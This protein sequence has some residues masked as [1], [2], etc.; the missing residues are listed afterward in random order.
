MSGWRAGVRRKSWWMT[1]GESLISFFRSTLSMCRSRIRP[2]A[3]YYVNSSQ[4][5]ELRLKWGA[6]IV[7]FVSE[8][9]TFSFSSCW[10]MAPWAAA[11]IPSSDSSLEI[12]SPSCSPGSCFIKFVQMF[13]RRLKTWTQSDFSGFCCHT[14][15]SHQTLTS[16][17]EWLVLDGGRRSVVFLIR[18]VTGEEQTAHGPR[19]TFTE[20]LIM[21]SSIQLL[22]PPHGG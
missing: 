20:T 13:V 5:H 19:F 21:N 1:G 4:E 3:V 10:F 8:R 22:S 14:I 17:H 9:S 2:W 6:V 15:S 18:L 12:K 7:E 11:V 16:L